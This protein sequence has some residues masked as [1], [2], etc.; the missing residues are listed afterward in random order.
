MVRRVRT[1][2]DEDNHP[3]YSGTSCAS[4][5]L[6]VVHQSYLRCYGRAWRGPMKVE[7]VYSS[8]PLRSGKVRGNQQILDTPS[9]GPGSRKSKVN[10]TCLLNKKNKKHHSSDFMILAGHCSV[11]SG[12]TSNWPSLRKQTSTKECSKHDR[13]TSSSSS[14]SGSLARRPVKSCRR[15]QMCSEET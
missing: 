11:G 8:T 6:C 13:G 14:S 10:V 1:R 7:H 5:Y 12:S 3:D 9:G 4:D 15:C 2:D